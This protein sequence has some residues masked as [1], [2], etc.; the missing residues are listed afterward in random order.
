MTEIVGVTFPIPK[1]YISRFFT[2]RKTVFIKPACC[3]KLLKPGMK[4]VFYQSHED[5]GFVGEG[6]I[7]C[8]SFADEPNALVEQFENQLFLTREEIE[9]YVDNQTQWKRIRVREYIV[10]KKKW[11][12]IELGDIKKYKQTEKPVLFVPDRRKI[13]MGMISSL[14]QYKTLIGKR[15]HPH[16][17]DSGKRLLEP[18]RPLPDIEQ[19][20]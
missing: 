10:K 6:K 11:M 13:F 1:K 15:H 17:P 20:R 5:T 19:R 2:Y 3:Y 18:L 8:I 7:V 12:A 9:T 16:R 4:F 14:T